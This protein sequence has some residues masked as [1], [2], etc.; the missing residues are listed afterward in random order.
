VA[1]PSKNFIFSQVESNVVSRCL[2][3]V[4]HLPGTCVGPAWHLC[5]T[6]LAPVWH[7]PGTCVA[8]AWHP[9]GTCPAPVWHLSGTRVARAWHLLGTC[10]AP[11][12]HQLGRIPLRTSELH[13]RDQ[14]PM[15]FACPSRTTDYCSP[16]ISTSFHPPPRLMRIVLIS[17]GPRAKAILFDTPRNISEA[18]VRT[19]MVS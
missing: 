6:C 13:I 2:A 5:G 8:P 18:F 7:L 9:C 19:P 11:A 4:W 10:V 15:R 1:L 14:D 12:R 16:I 3:P 17:N